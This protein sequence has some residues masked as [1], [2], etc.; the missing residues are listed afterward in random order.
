MSTKGT[1]FLTDDNCH[2]YEEVCPQHKGHRTTFC[3][4]VNK[5]DILDLS[6]GI[7]GLFVEIKIDSLLAKE[8]YEL[9]NCRSKLKKMEKKNEKNI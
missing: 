6:Y 8:I 1:I 9:I 5:E 4:E 7:D 3:I 2:W